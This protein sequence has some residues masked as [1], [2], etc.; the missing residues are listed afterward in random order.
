MNNNKRSYSPSGYHQCAVIVVHCVETTE[1]MQHRKHQEI[2][3]LDQR[4]SAKC[5]AVDC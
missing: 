5:V 2:R 1:Y 3:R 4:P